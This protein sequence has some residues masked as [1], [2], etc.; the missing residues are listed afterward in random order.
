VN[1]GVVHPV[2]L[3]VHDVVA[4]L[5]VLENFRHT[6][7]RC[8]GH[9]CRS[10][11]GAQQQGPPRHR[12]LTLGRDHGLDV[13]AVAFTEVAV[14]LVVDRVELLG[15]LLD[16]LPAEVG[17]RVLR[18]RAAGVGAHGVSVRSEVDLDVA[19]GGIDACADRLVC[20]LADFPGAEVSELSGFQSPDAG[21]ADTDPATER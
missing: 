10:G 17:E 21:M 1:V 7:T 5:H 9:P 20:G 12:K 15:Q 4:D 13:P 8:A 16:R 18:V 14:D 6:E 19:F 11:D 3:T 2:P